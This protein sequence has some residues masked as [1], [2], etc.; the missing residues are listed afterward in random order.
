MELDKFIEET[1]YHVIHRGDLTCKTDYA[2][3]GQAM[4]NK[5]PCINLDSRVGDVSPWV[6][7]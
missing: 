7:T 5:Y 3:Y 2:W 4:F 1:A 6:L